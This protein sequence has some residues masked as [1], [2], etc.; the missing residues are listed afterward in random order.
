MFGAFKSLTQCMSSFND[1][2]A[3][4]ATFFIEFLRLS[5]FLVAGRK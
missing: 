4:D 3:K 1:L 5:L 2:N